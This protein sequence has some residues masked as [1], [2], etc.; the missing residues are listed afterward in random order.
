MPALAVGV[1]FTVAL[2]EG[3]L[4]EMLIVLASSRALLPIV[5][6]VVA[7]IVS[8]PVLVAP[9]VRAPALAVGNA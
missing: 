4:A 2:I 6:V 7:L 9:P 5:V 8:E 1:E 3:T